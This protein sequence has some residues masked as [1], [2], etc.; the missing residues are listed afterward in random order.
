MFSLTFTLRRE[1]LEV[2][3]SDMTY[4]LSKGHGQAAV[5]SVFLNQVHDVC[6][7]VSNARRISMASPNLDLNWSVL[8]LKKAFIQ[9]FTLERKKGNKGGKRGE[10]QHWSPTGNW[11]REVAVTVDGS[12]HLDHYRTPK[13]ACFTRIYRRCPLSACGIPQ[14]SV[15]L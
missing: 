10:M 2:H 11:T 1:S 15:C 14:S 5:S 9:R 6:Q 12:Q 7:W 13:Q 3:P 4:H 8:L